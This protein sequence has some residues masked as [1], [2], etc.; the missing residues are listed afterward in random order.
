MS[1][2]SQNNP[3]ETVGDVVE[4]T[5]QSVGRSLIDSLR[6]RFNPGSQVRQGDQ[7]MDQSRD[8]L[9]RHLQLIDRDDQVTIRHHFDKAR[10]AKARLDE[11]GGSQIQRYIKA[12]KYKLLSKEMFKVVKKASDRAIE[13][14]L[15][16]Q[17]AEATRVDGSET[18]NN[19]RNPFTDSRVISSLANIAVSDLDR[20]NMSTYQS[21]GTGEAAV[22]LDLHDRDASAQHIVA[23]FPSE[24]FSGNK[25]D[26]EASRSMA[27]GET[28]VALSLHL[29]DGSTRYFA[30]APLTNV[31]SDPSKRTEGG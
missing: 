25:T 11:A 13:G 14:R 21:E 26:E 12:R 27:P 20:V 6:R 28:V 4:V 16:D 9:Q 3:P 18:G 19:S 5:G 23:T 15:M 22:V 1:D 8:M 29:Q 31:P 17:I 24:V 30:T 7:L 2:L 10:N